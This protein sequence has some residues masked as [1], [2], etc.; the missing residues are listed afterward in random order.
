MESGKNDKQSKIKQAMKEI[1]ISLSKSEETL[2]NSIDYS[3]FELFKRPDRDLFDINYE[4][5]PLYFTFKDVYATG[6]LV[7]RNGNSR[8]IKFSIPYEG[9]NIIEFKRYMDTYLILCTI[10]YSKYLKD[11][12]S[13]L[14]QYIKEGII[15][16]DPF[17]I[18]CKEKININD[19]FTL[20]V[21]IFDN[22]KIKG[23]SLESITGK[24][25]IGDIKVKLTSFTGI[26]SKDND[27]EPG[28]L[29]FIINE[30]K[31][32]RLIETVKKEPLKYD[33][34]DVARLINSLKNK[35]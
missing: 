16:D 12:D 24:Q 2:D 15:I 35:K 11:N 1:D 21:T 26:Q 3:K 32:T 25:F 28:R 4:R 19:K 10:Y 23:V 34:K 7:G 14:D 22:M 6:I 29:N 13:L 31:V 5:K 27:S 20:F 18:Y 30:I 17:K 8:Y 33:M 9:D